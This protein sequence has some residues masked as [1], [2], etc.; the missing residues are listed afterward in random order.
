MAVGT[1]AD[2]LLESGSSRR[3]C[4]SP[5]R[6]AGGPLRCARILRPQRGAQCRATRSPTCSATPTSRCSA[7]SAWA[8]AACW[9]GRARAKV[10][11][12][13]PRCTCST[14]CR[15]SGGAAKASMRASSF[16]MSYSLDSPLRSLHVKKPRLPG[17]PPGAKKRP[18]PRDQPHIPLQ[19]RENS[20]FSGARTPKSF[21]KSR[22]A[23]AKDSHTLTSKIAHGALIKGKVKPCQND[24]LDN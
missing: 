11:G 6:A 4:R 7:M 20:G 23:R 14:A 12:S 9:S 8:A 17:A 22:A 1:P 18:Y 13:R 15:R 5:R 19:G 10:D 21:K 3:C 24:I 16:N 2:A